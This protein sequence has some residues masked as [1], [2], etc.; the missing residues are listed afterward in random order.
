MEMTLRRCG[1]SPHRRADLTSWKFALPDFSWHAKAEE[2]LQ[3]FGGIRVDISGPG[4][5]RAQEPFEFDPEL[6]IGE[7]ERFS[8]LSQTF[9]HDF[10][11]LG[12]AGQGEFFL[13]IDEEGV[14]YLLGSW[15]LRLGF[16]DSA[17]ENLIMGIA[18]ERLTLPTKSTP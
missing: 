1:W 6:A 16:G 3:E 11:P 12:E 10:F 9:G 18:A 15:A 2:F 5:T 4:I 13:A 14:I 8:E 17:L 7:E